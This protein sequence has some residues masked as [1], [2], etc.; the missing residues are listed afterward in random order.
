MLQTWYRDMTKAQRV[1]VWILSFLAIPIFLIG[2][3]STFLLIYL[4]LGNRD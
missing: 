3:L 2:V 1:F 4:H